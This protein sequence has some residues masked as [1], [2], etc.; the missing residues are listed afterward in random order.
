MYIYDIKISSPKDVDKRAFI[1][2]TING[3]RYKEYNGNRLNLNIKPNKTKSLKERN[4][5]LKQ[6]EFEY[7]KSLEN[8][9]YQKL[10]GESQ[11]VSHKTADLLTTALKQKLRSNLSPK[12]AKALKTTCD[13][14]IFFLTEK[15]LSGNIGLLSKHRVQE[16]L[17]KFRSTPTY[18]LSKRRELS[19]IFGYLK[20]AY[21]LKSNLINSTD[22][23]KTK[24]SLHKIYTQEQLHNILSYLKQHHE[25]LYLCC[26]ISYGCFLRPHIEVRN[27]KGS[28]FKSD[29]TEIHL[30]GNENKSGRVRTVYVPDY[31]KEAIAER[32]KSLKGGHNLFSFEEETYN[33]YYFKT[34]WSRHFKIMLS[35]GL[36]E[37]K[38][39][40]Y[41]FRH[42]AAVNVYKK[43]KDL[44][45]L[46]QLLGHSNM[47]VTLKYLRG[48]G[49][50]NMEELKDVMPVL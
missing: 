23:L 24:A 7:R 42:T 17:N 22:K 12:Y 2:I 39:T 3:V 20:N 8:G 4:H 30:S 41:S 1:S 33:E 27:L 21:G 45:L 32:V 35:M 46:Q 6:L 25:N 18:Y 31:V 44:H 26:L 49:V 5:L 14:F 43:T 9:V 11:E 50:H 34:A 47:I 29:C 38:Q 19:S 37:Q 13:D 48:L 10:V 28:H 40:I 15:E 36:V 16:Y